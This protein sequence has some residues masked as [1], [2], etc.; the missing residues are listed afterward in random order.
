MMDMKDKVSFE[1]AL[2]DW[3]QKWE[4]FL[5]ERSINLGI[6][7]SHYTHK[8]LRSTYRSLKNNLP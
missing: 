6:G 3:F 1:G 4:S 5:N 2:N 7:K 8:R